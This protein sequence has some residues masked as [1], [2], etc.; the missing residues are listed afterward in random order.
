MGALAIK[1]FYERIEPYGTFFHVL[2]GLLA[3]AALWY[4][5]PGFVFAVLDFVAFDEYQVH[6][7][8]R[9]T[10]EFAEWLFGLVVGFFARVL[11]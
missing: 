4:G 6:D 2:A 1:R 11:A 7:D 10:W 3:G 9:P 8:N 5:P